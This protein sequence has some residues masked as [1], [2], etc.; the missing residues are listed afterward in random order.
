M[1][2]HTTDTKVNMFFECPLKVTHLKGLKLRHLMGAVRCSAV[3]H[4]LVDDEVPHND[5]G[6]NILCAH[7]RF[8][9][10]VLAHEAE[11]KGLLE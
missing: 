10:Y 11:G 3:S 1:T 5:L 9:T 7:T 4:N 2:A 6:Y 8:V